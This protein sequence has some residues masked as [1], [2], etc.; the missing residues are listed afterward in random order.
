MIYATVEL[1]ITNPDSFAAYGEKAGAALKKY[2]GAPVA[3]STEPTRIEGDG[4]AP[5]RAVVLSFPDK[6]SALGWINDPELAQV[7]ALR[8]GAGRSEILLLG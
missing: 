3:M 8:T 5:T 7:H 4:A 2:G 1:T 6:D